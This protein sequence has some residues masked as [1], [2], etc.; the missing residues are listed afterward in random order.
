MRS[1]SWLLLLG[2]PLAVEF[3]KA[4]FKVR[5]IDPD[6]RKIDGIKQGR[7]HVEDVPDEELA[8]LVYAELR[9]VARGLMRR[10]RPGQ[11]QSIAS[12]SIAAPLGSAATCTQARAGNGSLRNSV[13]ISLTVAKCSRATNEILIFTALSRL[14]PLASA[15]AWRFLNT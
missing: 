9:Q 14:P 4:G 3:A 7:S 2:L 12:T 13:I 15:T 1:L 6:K 5:G 8:P 11:M 10:E